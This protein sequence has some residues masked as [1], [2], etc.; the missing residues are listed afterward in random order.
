[1]DNVTA[2]FNSTSQTNNTASSYVDAYMPPVAPPNQGVFPVDSGTPAVPQQPE[3][4]TLEAPEPVGEISAPEPQA[5]LPAATPAPT[6]VSVPTPAPAPVTPASPVQQP[7]PVQ[8]SARTQQS[9]ELEDQNIFTMLGVT[10]G[11]PE[12]RETFLD[13]LQQVIWEDFLEYDV[14]L[15]ITRD[16]Q[17]ELDKLLGGENKNSMEDQEKI[18]IFLEKLIPD[19]EEIMLEKALE[20]KE[21]MMRE[22][23]TGMLE[24]FKD[25]PEAIT[26]IK[27]AETLINVGKWHSAATLLNSIR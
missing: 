21:E 15:L 26:G 6:P 11:T 2:Q 14:K 1:M 10:D 7:Q 16:E 22:R 8:P 25:K 13:E 27:N 3:P 18:V 17:L 4:K 23:I 19:L 20:L 9:E 12:Q 5:V 24:F